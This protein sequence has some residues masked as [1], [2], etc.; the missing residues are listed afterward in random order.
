MTL[1]SKIFIYIQNFENTMHVVVSSKI[2]MQMKIVEDTYISLF[3]NISI[4]YFFITIL[5]K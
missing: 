3:N 1:S 4:L 2:L 5:L